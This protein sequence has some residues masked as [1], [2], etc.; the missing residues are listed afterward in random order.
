MRDKVGVL[1]LYVRDFPGMLSFHRDKLG[2]PMS[3]IHPEK[4]YENLVDWARFEPN[5]STAIEFFT[6]SRHGRSSVLP[7]PLNNA[8]VIAFKV[9]HIDA[10]YAELRSREVEFPKEIGEEE[11]GRYVHFKDPERNRLQLYQPHPGY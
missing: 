7:F 5:G 4:G 11:W 2:L 1:L 10:A 9:E 8:F 3:K 6:E